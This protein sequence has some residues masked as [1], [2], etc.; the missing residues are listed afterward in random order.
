MGLC[1][2][3]TSA[4]NNGASWEPRNDN[5]DSNVDNRDHQRTNMGHIHQAKG[6][7]KHL[8]NNGVTPIEIDEFSHKYLN[9]NANGVAVQID[10]PNTINVSSSND[11]IRIP[12]EKFKTFVGKYLDIFFKL[13]LKIKTN[14]K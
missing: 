6:D 3:V 9:N 8:P 2:Q 12:Q 5:G 1:K 7:N 13:S 10:L 4:V 14:Y 11:N